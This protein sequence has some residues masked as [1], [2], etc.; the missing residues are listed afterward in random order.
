M[1]QEDAVSMSDV[2][3]KSQ[4]SS[5]L[6]GWGVA[7][8]SLATRKRQESVS[9]SVYLASDG[10]AGLRFYPGHPLILQSELNFFTWHHSWT[11]Q[12]IGMLWTIFRSFSHILLKYTG[13]EK[14]EHDV[15]QLTLG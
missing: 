7:Q 4:A 12:R 2:Y 3:F 5:S 10:S 15:N 8:M 11:N 14:N 1:H 13:N 9:R 6:S